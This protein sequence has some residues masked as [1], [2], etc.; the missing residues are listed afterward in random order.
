LGGYEE[1]GLMKRRPRT[2]VAGAVLGVVPWFSS[3][4]GRKCR[5]PV[6]KR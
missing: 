1:L 2:E 6:I 3:I 5:V 4:K